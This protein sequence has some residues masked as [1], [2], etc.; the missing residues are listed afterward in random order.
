MIFMVTYDS[1]AEELEQIQKISKDLAAKMSEDRWKTEQFT[2]FRKLRHYIEDKPLMDMLLYDISQ[3][4]PLEYLHQIREKYQM[5]SILLMADIQTS[6]ME[7]MRPGIRANSL[8]LRPW[9]KQQVEE[10]LREFIGEYLKMVKREKQEGSKAFVIE[11]KEGRLSVP[12]D[13]IYFFE[14]REKK[15]YIC[16]GKEEFG[17]YHT[18]DK[19]AEKL[20]ENFVRCH[21]G[22]IVNTDKIRKIMLSKSIIYLT[23]G[24]DV[25]LSRS[26]KSVLK[27]FGK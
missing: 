16:V 1:A 15:I 6:P 17:F 25:P 4:E 26:Y 27:G 12:Y 3:K 9:T 21:R 22:F 19:L 2:Q 5:A 7:Y 13:Q 11:S 24:F 18:I 23:D 14:A 20:P 10:V 8:L